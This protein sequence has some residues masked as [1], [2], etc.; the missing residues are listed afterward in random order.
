MKDA[1]PYARS[2][3]STVRSRTFAPFAQSSQCV[4]SF[5][6]WLMPP[7]LGTKIIP[8][9]PSCAIFCASWPAPLGSRVALRR[10]D[11]GRALDRA[12]HFRRRRGRR[13]AA[14]AA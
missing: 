10:S 13:I 5:G 3:S 12:L 8:I 4:S 9:G 6:E 1:E 14:Q 11:D 2:I 7:T